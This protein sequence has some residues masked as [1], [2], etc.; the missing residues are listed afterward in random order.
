MQH[1][2]YEP[3]EQWPAH[4]KPWWREPLGNAR[5]AGWHLQVF[6]G[7]AWGKVVC[8]R[9]MENPCTKA[10]FSTGRSG[11]AH[12]KDL[13]RL[14]QRCPHLGQGQ[15]QTF[16]ERV[17]KTDDLID[18]AEML[19]NAAEWCLA[20]ESD[21]AAANDLLERAQDNVAAAERSLDPNS[22]YLLSQAI[23]LDQSAQAGFGKAH[24]LAA[25]ARYPLTLHPTASDL[26]DEAT[27]RI[28]AAEATVDPAWARGTTEAEIR[29]ARIRVLRDHAETIRLRLVGRPAQ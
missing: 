16:T 24:A 28:D 2:W 29:R 9:T 19:L 13:M 12:A 20:A 3:D 14:L 7:H 4:P 10:I 8:S 26:T 11:E 21:T 1:R 23:E 27:Q 6:S 18:G 5:A 25:A 17:R 15:R 22:D